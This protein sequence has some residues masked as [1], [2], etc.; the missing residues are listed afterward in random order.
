MLF[1]DLFRSSSASV[2]NTRVNLGS[3][4]Q[5]TIVGESQLINARGPPF[6]QLP[7]FNLNL[8]GLNLQL[9]FQFLSQ[10]HVSRRKLVAGL[11]YHV[12]VAG[13][14]E[15]DH[16]TQSLAARSSTPSSSSLD[17]QL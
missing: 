13:D 10:L 6:F 2:L 1:K 5:Y 12:V 11:C 14:E 15:E 17:P 9:L 4:S 3:G 16:A 7:F 8:F